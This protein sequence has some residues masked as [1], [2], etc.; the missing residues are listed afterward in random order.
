MSEVNEMLVGASF[1]GQLY[2]TLHPD[3]FMANWVVR[4]SVASQPPFHCML[5][6]S[7]TAIARIL[8]RKLRESAHSSLNEV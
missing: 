3:R 4:P 2:Q 1:Q 7:P 6:I 8:I 5:D